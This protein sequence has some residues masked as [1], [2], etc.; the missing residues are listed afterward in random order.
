MTIKEKLL[1]Q[2]GAAIIAA[3]GDDADK[4]IDEYEIDSADIDAITHK[5]KF[6]L[7]LK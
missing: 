7:D 2:Y 4:D 1:E 3:L 5:V 6:Y